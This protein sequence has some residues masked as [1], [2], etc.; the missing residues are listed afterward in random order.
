MY[1][2][3]IKNGRL[4]DGSGNPW[5]RADLAVKDGKIVKIA[6]QIEGE[7]ARVIDAQGLT[8]TPGFVDLHTH[9]DESILWNRHA[10]S[11]VHAGVT[12]EGVGQ[13]GT[14]A[15]CFTEGYENNIRMELFPFAGIAPDQIEINWR[16]LGEWR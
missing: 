3:I 5:F 14:G 13:C 16:S 10:R 9:S 6:R 8:V 11:S 1:D 7:A 2:L 15:Y 12:T 4:I